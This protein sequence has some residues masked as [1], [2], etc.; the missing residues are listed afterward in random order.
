M[1]M[2]GKSIYRI[3]DIEI[4]PACNCLRRQNE[5]WTL[6]QK[7]FQVLLYLLEH[8]HRLVTKEELLEKVWAGA[9]VTDDTLVQIIVELRKTLGDDARHP[10]YIRTI[11]KIGYHFIAEVSELSSTPLPG[12]ALVEVE[13]VTTVQVELAQAPD[14]EMER[15]G[16]RRMERRGDGAGRRGGI[17]RMEEFLRR[18]L[19]TLVRSVAPSSRHPV[20]LF[21]MFGLLLLLTAAWFVARRAGEVARPTVTLPHVPGKKPVAVM[22]FENRANDRELDWLREGLADMLIASLSRSQR[23][24]LLSRQ[25]LTALLSQIGRQDP[26]QIKLEDSQEIAKRAQAETMIL[27]GFARLGDKVRIDVTLHDAKTG[28]LQAAESLIADSPAQILTQIDLLSLKL[29]THLGA[30]L[31][32]SDAQ[33]GLA[34]LM[35]NNLDAYRYYSLALEQVQM[36]QFHDAIALLEKALALDPNFAMA[37]ARIGYVYAV[38]MGQGD[39]AKPHL[40]KAM[41]FADRL[42]EKDKLFITAWQANA[43]RDTMRAIEVYQEITAR[44]PME[45]EAYVRLSVLLQNQNRNDEAYRVIQQGLVTDPEWKDLYNQLGG[46]CMRQGRYEEARVA[47]QHYIQLAPNDPNAWDSLGALHQWF[48]HYNEAEAAYN[49]AL[50]LNPE[51]SVAIIHLGNLRFQ[52]GRY[53]AAREQYQRYIQIARDDNARVRGIGSLAWVAAK[54]KDWEGVATATR[55]GL[56]YGS[57][58]AWHALVLALERREATAVTKWS[59]VVF[60][61]ANFDSLKERGSLRI[62][63]YQRGYVA[64][65]QGRADE[66]IQHFRTALTH[67]AVEWNIDSFESCLADALLELGRDDEAIAEYER[68]LKINPNY[69]L[70]HFHLGQAYDHKSDREKARTAYQHFLQVWREADADIPE[71]LAAQQRLAQP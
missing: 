21:A 8:R 2:L 33:H 16:D 69:P 43:A 68:I 9:A 70:A 49:R 11:P 37:H 13:E 24:T 71:I 7:S 41:T 54:Q 44:Y 40:D 48:G 34:A 19:W 52:Q 50:A 22:Y 46:V 4:D 64:L 38:R 45:T 6:R 28:Q 35:T 61:A 55:E 39:K 27:G 32:A 5:E 63:E 60:A 51:S 23:L 25:Q 42:S 18:V 67:R 36:Y 14:R 31:A 57:G 56:R 3:G 12:A 59:E 66:A 53:R 29:A 26:T 10:Q 30:T 20:A 62:W 17:E 47:N 58:A 1:Q 15:R 65:R